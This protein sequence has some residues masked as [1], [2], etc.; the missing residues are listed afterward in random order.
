MIPPVI[1]FNLYFSLCAVA[2]LTA[3]VLLNNY[4]VTYQRGQ[5]GDILQIFLKKQ[6]HNL[7]LPYSSIISYNT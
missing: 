5:K 1:A 3:F 6:E 4:T 2:V 7:L